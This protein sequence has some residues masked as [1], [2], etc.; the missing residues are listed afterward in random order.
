MMAPPSRRVPELMD[1]LVE[2]ILLRFPP[3]DPASLF[4]ASL[5]SKRWRRLVSSP[6]FHR[7]FREFHRTPPMLGFFCNIGRV[8]EIYRCGSGDLR[9][10]PA[11]E[12]SF[13]LLP[14]AAIPSWHALDALH[15]RVLFYDFDDDSVTSQAVRSRK[16][17]RKTSQAV[18]VEVELIVWNPATGEVC[19]LPVVRPLHMFGW[20]AALLCAAARCDDHVDACCSYDAFRVIVVAA[21]K[22]LT[23]AYVYSSEQGAW[24]EPI[25]V[26][27]LGVA[28]RLTN[29]LSARTRDALYFLNGSSTEILEYDMGKHEVSFI[30]LP[31]VCKDNQ[32]ISLMAMEDGGLGFAMVERSKL[33]TWSK[34]K[35]AGG[36]DGDAGWAR[37]RVIELSKL[38]PASALS[39]ATRVVAFAHVPNVCFIATYSKLFTICMRSGQV[40]KLYD[41]SMDR[42]IRDIVPYISFC[43]PALGA[44]PADEGPRSRVSSTWGA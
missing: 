15:G 43:I 32:F 20:N 16:R 7:R 35:G 6:G 38:L 11:A 3:V 36:V 14:H 42:D 41:D 23:S 29:G 19:R 8:P 5:V 21:F 4:R 1:E 9:F 25:S 18:E 40:S 10:M 37:R 39:L 12:S 2:D 33:Y 44:V 13:R 30:N 22:G 28:V 17:K 34:P 24:S 26:Q 27:H 31:S